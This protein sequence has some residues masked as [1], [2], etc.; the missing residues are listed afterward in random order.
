[1]HVTV[2]S[3][4]EWAEPKVATY[5]LDTLRDA[6][7][8]VDAA[9]YLSQKINR[10]SPSQEPLLGALG[11]HPFNLKQ[12]IEQELRDLKARNISLVFIFSG[13]EFGKSDYAATR[14]EAARGAHKAAWEFYDQGQA[15]EVVK[16]FSRARPSKS[17]PTP[18]WS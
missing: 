11:G 7:I 14:T 12:Q 2:Q 18:E 8:G 17:Q 1:M 16:A 15:E 10:D 9:Y 13:L 5:S 4:E 6:A 3:I